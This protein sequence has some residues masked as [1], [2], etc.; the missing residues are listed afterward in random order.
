MIKKNKYIY[1]ISL[2]IPVLILLI[3]FIINNVYPFGSETISNSDMGQAY[4]PAYYN[5]WD[6]FHGNTN[7]FFNYNVG[8]GT[9]IYDLGSIYGFFDPTNWIVALSSRSNIPYI[10]NFI[11]IIK[12]SLIS[13][14]S[15]YVFKKLFSK[16]SNYFIILFSVLYA[17][18][19]YTIM[20]HTNIPWLSITMLFPL[21]LLGLKN[22]FDNKSSYLYI[23]TLFLTL[24]FSLY[25]SYMILLFVLFSTGIYLYI[26]I[27]KKKRKKYIFKLGISTL[28]SL[29][30]SAFAT[31]PVLYQIL[32]SYRYSVNDVTVYNSMEGTEFYNKIVLLCFYGLPIFLLFKFFSKYKKNKKEVLFIG[33]VLLLTT[34]TIFIEPINLMWHTGNYIMFPYR[35]A[36]IPIFFIYLASLFYINKYDFKFIMYDTN[37]NNIIAII[38]ASIF[39]IIMFVIYKIFYLDEASYLNPGNA[40]YIGTSIFI[41]IAFI[42]SLLINVLISKLDISRISKYILISILLLVQVLFHSTLFIGVSRNKLNKEF[43]DESAFLANEIYDYGVK[44]KTLYKYKDIDYTMFENYPFISKKSSLSTWHIM[45]EDQRLIHEYLGYSFKAVKLHDHGGTIFSDQILGINRLITINS[46]ND[47]YKEIGSTNSYKI[48]EYKKSIPYGIV[49]NKE[50]KLSDLD[51]SNSKIYINNLIYQ[52]LFDREDKLFNKPNYTKEENNDYDKYVFDFDNKTYL[53][54][55]IKAYSDTLYK[56]EVNNKTVTVPNINNEKNT[57]F[58]MGDGFL[59]LGTYEGK[60][61]VLVYKDKG[62]KYLSSFISIPYD[63]I[64]NLIDNYSNNNLDISIDNNKISIKG[65]SDKNKSLFIPITYNKGL[66]AYNNGKRVDVNKSMGS[67]ISVDL[68]EKD[69]NIEIRYYPPYLNISIIISIISLILLVIYIKYLNNIN[70]E[71]I[72]KVTYV[73]YIITYI[74]MFLYIHVFGFFKIIK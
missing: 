34:I 70:N 37:R 7:L 8:A 51:Y 40:L 72:F 13:L 50:N 36:F 33:S 73:I 55:D 74:L 21:L 48:Y 62:T 31:I 6:L 28:I 2:I 25:L 17:L 23:I 69:N 15:C 60:V 9:N 42:Y 14:T 53:Y 45:S 24:I 54:F 35:F 47:D 27:D 46:L 16:V 20:Y 43:N 22:I 26:F 11:L 10:I 56:I 18:S 52:K 1:L 4:L 64:W 5:L 59:N 67:F 44:D 29:G 39:F 32:T 61:E 65:D 66:Y 12:I 71:F 58:Y 30:L 38:L 3:V 63:K 19:S 57:I 41:V 68:L 49:Y